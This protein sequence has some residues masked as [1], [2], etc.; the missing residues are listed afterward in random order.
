MPNWTQVIDRFADRKPNPRN[1]DRVEWSATRTEAMGGGTVVRAFCEDRTLYS[2]G[3]HFPLA[4]YLGQ[5]HDGRHV[6]LKNGDRNSPTTN[7]M[8]AETQSKCYGPTV[9][10]S[11][12]QAAGLAVP[13]LADIVDWREAPRT[14][15]YRDTRTGEFYRNWD[16]RTQSG[17]GDP[18]P[19][20][21]QG[22]WMPYSSSQGDIMERGTWHVLGATLIRSGD[23]YYLC[24]L[25]EGRY[26]VS[27]LAAPAASVDE[28]FEG[29]KPDAVRTAERDGLPVVR[30]GEWFFLP[31]GLDD[32]AMARELGTTKAGLARKAKRD[33]LP[34][35]RNDSNVH[36]VK[37]VVTE[38]GRRFAR[39]RVFHRSPGFRG[40]T[41]TLTREHKTINLG[42]RWHLVVA[43]T[44]KAAWSMGGS[45]D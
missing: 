16:Y 37:Q 36:D 13:T 42:D 35:Q 44:Q 27:E 41:G 29:L 1:G 31:T 17:I 10:L 45:F 8:V 28:A 30:Q 12:L 26:F 40:E 32:G 21:A 34:R 20:P 14:M 2:Y 9:S 39:G 25:D 24:S 18:F 11:A 19:R 22:Q 3:T 4:H 38:D 7:R 5:D 43:N 23:R 15:L 33:G 6:F